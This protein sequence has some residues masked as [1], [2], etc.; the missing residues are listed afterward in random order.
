[1]LPQVAHTATCTAQHAAS[2]QLKAAK[3]AMLGK[4]FGGRRRRGSV[5]G[6][7]SGSSKTSATTKPGSKALAVPIPAAGPVRGSGGRAKSAG[8]V[9]VG[10]VPS[11]T[12]RPASA[13]ASVGGQG[14][15][16]PLG[17]VSIHSFFGR[18]AVNGIKRE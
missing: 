8:G 14:S 18:A 15:K 3:A 9:V 4:V 6:K 11:C 12:G 17:T 13:G 2:A 7:R 10:S 5:K 1:M 16:R